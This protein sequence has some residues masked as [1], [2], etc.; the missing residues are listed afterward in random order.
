MTLTHSC[1]LNG[2]NAFDY[3]NTLQRESVAVANF[4]EQ[5]M[6][7]NYADTLR[8]RGENSATSTSVLPATVETNRCK[9]ERRLGQRMLRQR[10]H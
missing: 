4:P 6:P 5:W 3:L 8:N 7:W 2:V 10:A 1:Q 9:R